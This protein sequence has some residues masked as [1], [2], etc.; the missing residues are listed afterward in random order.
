[1]ANKKVASKGVRRARSTTSARRSS[2]ASQTRSANSGS[3][4]NY[5]NFI[6]EWS[7]KPAVRYVAGGLAAAALTKLAMNISEK[8]PAIS[9]FLRENLDLVEERLTEFRDSFNE[10]REIEAH[11]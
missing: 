3:G 2:T 10:D 8:Y 4:R 6:R 11:H 1:M 7:A 5:Y 9:S